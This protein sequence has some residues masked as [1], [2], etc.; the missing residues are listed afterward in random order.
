[1]SR[2]KRSFSCAI[3]GVVY[4]ISRGSNMKIDLVAAVLAIAVG[5]VL[6]ISRLEWALIILAIFMVLSAETFN[7][8]IEKTVDLITKEQHPIAGLAKDLGAGGVL[9]TAINAVIIAIIVY[10]PYLVGIWSDL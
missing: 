2:L 4:S 6:G 5:F 7:T 10:G 9:L 8:A 3:Q 1:M